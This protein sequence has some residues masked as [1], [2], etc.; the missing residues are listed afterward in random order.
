MIGYLKRLITTGFA[1][2]ISDIAA[3]FLAVFLLPI[4][5]RHLTR[6]DYGTAELLITG[7]ILV[8]IIARLGIGEA[9]VRFHFIDS[10]PQR[11]Q[12][13]ARTALGVL[14]IITTVTATIAAVAAGPLSTAL[15]GTPY[16]AEFRAAAL[17]LWAFTNLELAYALLRAEGRA[18]TYAIA[19]LC[20]VGLTVLL[21]IWLVVFADQGAFG[22]LIGNYAASAAALV[23][24]WIVLGRTLGGIRA[25]LGID[26]RE[27]GA[28]LRF[29][30]PTVPAEASV[31]ALFFIDRLWLYRF[32]SASAAGLYALAAKLATVVVLAVRAFQYAWPPLAYSIQDDA[33]AGRVYARVTTYYVLFCGLVVAGLALLGRWAVRI[34]AAPEYFAAH[35]AL[36]LIAL[37]WAL[38]G[39][40]LVLVVMAARAQVTVRN[41]PAALTGLIANVVLLALLVPPLGIVGAGIALCVSYLVMLTAMYFLTRSLFYVPF[42]WSRLMRL[43][44]TI[45]IVVVPAEFLLPGEGVGGLL[46]RIAVLA[47]LLPALGVVNFF[48][49]DELRAV[50]ELI[51]TRRLSRA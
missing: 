44:G 24:L 3:K 16:P 2:Q 49:E 37:G 34:L 43:V 36:P 13:I 8:S 9:L 20:N 32:Q 11:R 28:M 41:F 7:V 14:V 12:R 4:Y 40:F 5:T 29:G 30:L 15:F 25:G 19:S 50:R 38:Y 35:K 26:R 45:V 47:A 27:L 48:R 21:T 10:D 18:R 39:L 22:L 1:Y 31:F 51:Q 42:E 17:G 6:S 23:V 46:A 33:E